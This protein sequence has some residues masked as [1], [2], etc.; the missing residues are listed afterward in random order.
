MFEDTKYLNFHV[1]FPQNLRIREIKVLWNHSK[2]IHSWNP[3]NLSPTKFK[4]H[5]IYFLLNNSEIRQTYKF[6]I[7]FQNSAKQ[8]ILSNWLFTKTARTSECIE[9]W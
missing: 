8:N 7:K 3:R 2:I 6:D 5:K 1:F 4:S 9:Q